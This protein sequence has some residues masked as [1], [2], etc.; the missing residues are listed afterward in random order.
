M[1]PVN[2]TAI[3][4]PMSLFEKIRFPLLLLVTCCVL[5][6][7]VFPQRHY[8]LYTMEKNGKKYWVTVIDD[9][10]D[11]ELDAFFLGDRVS[12]ALIWEGLRRGPWI[13]ARL[14]EGVQPKMQLDEIGESFRMADEAIDMAQ[15]WI[16]NLY[17]ER[18]VFARGSEME[19]TFRHAESLKRKGS[20]LAF[21]SEYG[22]Q[23]NILAMSRMVT[24]ESP[25]ELCPMEEVV[26]GTRA[27]GRLEKLIPVADAKK[28]LVFQNITLGIDFLRD[29][30]PVRF[31]E[32]VTHSADSGRGELKSFARK[33]NEYLLG[34]LLTVEMA[35]GFF[36][37]S[38]Q[39]MIYWDPFTHKPWVRPAGQPEPAYPELRRE[40]MGEVVL[41]CH[42]DELFAFWKGKG[43][44]E[45]RH[46][47]S[48]FM[49]GVTTYWMKSTVTNL[50]ETFIAS[51]TGDLLVNQGM[52]LKVVA[53]NAVPSGYFAHAEHLG[54]SKCFAIY[55]SLAL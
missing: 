33:E 49:P 15:E 17:V 3:H 24:N 4:L 38:G 45:I 30:I 9:A 13:E 6:A 18:G 1:K 7:E 44:E 53:A 12:E 28:M 5:Q 51:Y 2:I 47:E 16:I 52:S 46:F 11:E 54:R 50:N 21:I 37:K 35:H 14:A 20:K 48:P 39:P 34:E 32:I 19:K 22:N 55:H 26:Q 8:R 27:E 42:G 41:E 10:R 25:D 31:Q 36:L 43:F 40:H 29:E 23:R